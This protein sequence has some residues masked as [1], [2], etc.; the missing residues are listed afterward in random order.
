[1]KYIVSLSNDAYKK[2]LQKGSIRRGKLVGFK[3]E[4]DDGLIYVENE[5]EKIL[6]GPYVKYC[7]EKPNYYQFAFN[8][9]Q[10]IRTQKKHNTGYYPDEEIP[11]ISYSP[12][13]Q[14]YPVVNND[15]FFT[16]ILWRL[17][18]YVGNPAK[19]GVNLSDRPPYIYQYV[20][21]KLGDYG[22]EPQP[23]S[24]QRVVIGDISN[25]PA[26]MLCFKGNCYSIQSEDFMI[27]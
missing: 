10:I 19:I 23:I 17:L 12:S 14:I 16:G 21:K 5:Q 15:L 27:G 2:F 22:F 7:S 4:N 6:S 25:L 3:E 1:M 24:N 20:L 26:I 8:S 13:P 9:C 18:S 11:E